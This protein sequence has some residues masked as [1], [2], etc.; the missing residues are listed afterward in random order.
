MFQDIVVK[1]QQN[2]AITPSTPPNPPA[3][4]SVS[5]TQPKVEAT[6]ESKNQPIQAEIPFIH[7][8]LHQRE[9][10][11]ALPDSIVV[12]NRQRRKRKCAVNRPL[13]A[14]PYAHTQNVIK[15][16]ES[17]EELNIL[18]EDVIEVGI[19]YHTFSSLSFLVSTCIVF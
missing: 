8:E 14:Q 15:E 13:P 16:E 10:T 4:G 17:G 6:D 12:D 9:E 2:L 1:I 7:S 3:P 18:D 5:A 11:P 19:F